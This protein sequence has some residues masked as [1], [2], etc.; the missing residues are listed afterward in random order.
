LTP[1]CSLRLT[2]LRPAA[3]SI[4]F[5]H[6]RA[7][8]IERVR[9]VR[10]ARSGIGYYPI[11]V[12]RLIDLL[13]VMELFDANTLWQLL[14]FDHTDMWDDTHFDRINWITLDHDTLTVTATF[15]HVS[16]SATLVST[17]HIPQRDAGVDAIGIGSGRAPK[18][19]PAHRAMAAAAL[20][21]N[22][23]PASTY[24]DIP[25]PDPL[26]TVEIVSAMR[27]MY[28]AVL[29]DAVPRVIAGEHAGDIH[30]SDWPI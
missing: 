14:H 26:T 13:P 12:Y 1:A 7:N 4:P 28:D 15:N 24:R 9:R 19:A 8:M 23:F 30:T 6:Y 17:G 25:R 22:A 2:V 5:T 10:E 20:W 11:V 21:M 27:R 18:E 16:L 3:L 29:N